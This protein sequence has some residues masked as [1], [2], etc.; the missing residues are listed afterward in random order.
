MRHHI[1][2]PDSTDGRHVK[3]RNKAL[4]PLRTEATWAS[5]RAVQEAL[6]NVRVYGNITRR[7]SEIF[8]LVGDK[9]W[10]G[11]REERSEG[12]VECWIS[13]CGQW[14]GWRA[15]V[16]GIMSG[17]DISGDGGSVRGRLH[18]GN[19]RGDVLLLLLGRRHAC[20]AL[21]CVSR[22]G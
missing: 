18:S 19:G 8:Y 16:D 12:S 3:G 5:E 7:N 9:A 20:T 14:V 2:R 15:A 4:T 1:P 17:R 22:G 6:S 21:L 13:S 11:R 10:K